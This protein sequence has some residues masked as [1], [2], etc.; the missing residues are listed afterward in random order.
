MT[1]K[2]IEIQM[3][4]GTIEP[5]NLTYEEFNHWSHLTSQHIVRI[6]KESDEVR[7]RR[8]GQRDSE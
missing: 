2:E 4:L 1:N 6:I 8:R 5:Q 7:W 3:A